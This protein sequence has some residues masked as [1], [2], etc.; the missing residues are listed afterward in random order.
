MAPGNGVSGAICVFSPN[1]AIG[2]APLGT[3]DPGNDGHDPYFNE[4]AYTGFYT[5]PIR[6]RRV[7]PAI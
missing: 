1:V 4:D 3:A 5:P 2:F 7:S 6:S